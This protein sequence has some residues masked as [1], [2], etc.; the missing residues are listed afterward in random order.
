VR[1]VLAMAWRV[2][3]V[4]PALAMMLVATLVHAWKE[5]TDGDMP[6]LGSGGR[7]R[8][9][10]QETSGWGLPTGYRIETRWGSSTWTG[11]DPYVTAGR[12]MGFLGSVGVLAQAPPGQ[13]AGSVA[14]E[15]G[16]VVQPRA[17]PYGFTVVMIEPTVVI[18]NF[19]LVALTRG[20][21]SPQGQVL[22]SPLLDGWIRYGTRLPAT[23]TLLWFSPEA[24][25]APIPVSGQA[26]GNGEIVVKGI[27][28]ALQKRGDEWLVTRP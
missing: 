8:Y 25:Q 16:Q 9:Y 14:T 17:L 15:S 6:W 13:G 10:T 12:A 18:M 20:N 5:R 2:V 24:K 11:E 3:R 1:R 21:E 26:S 4:L 23:G 7:A 19:D 28:L 27:R 22:G